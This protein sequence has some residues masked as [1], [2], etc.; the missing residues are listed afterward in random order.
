V[1]NRY[2]RKAPVTLE[3][4]RSTLGFEEVSL[5][6]N[7]FDVVSECIN[8]GAALLDH[9]RGAAVTRAVM[10][11]ETRLGGSSAASKQ[12][13]LARTFASLRN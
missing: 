9:A 3:D 11:L 10:A 12:S 6:P 8:T 4:I 13:I 5:I 7:D 1:V 2:E